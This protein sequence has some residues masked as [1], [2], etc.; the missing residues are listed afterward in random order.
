[1]PAGIGYPPQMNAMPQNPPVGGQ[2]PMM[3]AP[4]PPQ[5][6]PPA[7]G[8]NIDALM[9]D[10]RIMML[11]QALM[12]GKGAGPMPPQMSEADLMQAYRG[13]NGT[14]DMPNVRKG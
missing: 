11:I 10:P 4:M 5:G 8:A 13:R 1:M 12:Q 14:M 7:G 2:G 6:M 3:G 9:Q